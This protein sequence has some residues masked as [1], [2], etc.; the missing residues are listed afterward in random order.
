MINIYELSEGA[1]NYPTVVSADRKDGTPIPWAALSGLAV[2]PAD[3]DTVYTVHDSFYQQSRIYAMDVSRQPAVITEEI[4]LKDGS[5]TVN[6]DPE[7][8][9]VSATGDGSF[10]VASEG[11]GS[12]DDPDRPVTSNNVLVHAA[13]DGDIIGTV[14]LPASVNEKQ[15][16]FGFEGVTSVMEAGDEVLYVAFQRAWIGDPE[17]DNVAALDTAARLREARGEARSAAE[18]AIADG[19]TRAV[20]LAPSND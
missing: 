20:A 17:P 3:S 16:R 12:V 19:H 13:A 15:R 2:D 5:L 4:V 18:R 7:G 11:A 1:P 8:I 10:W 6:L 9:A 14:S